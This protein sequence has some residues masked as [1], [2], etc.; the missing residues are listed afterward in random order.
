MIASRSGI[1]LSIVCAAAPAA[2]FLA[3]APAA[4]QH[5]F[6]FGNDS[7][8]VGAGPIWNNTDAQRKCPEVARREGGKWTGQWKT[9]SHSMNSICEVERSGSHRGDNRG[10]HKDNWVEAGPIFAQPQAEH[11]CPEVARN[12][13]GKWTGQW[14]TTQPGRMS[15]CEV[16]RR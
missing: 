16:A 11:R 15:V 7:K 9:P 1:A 14:K 5:H 12:A 8:W 2:L 4:A 10:R 3:S 6:S 13:G